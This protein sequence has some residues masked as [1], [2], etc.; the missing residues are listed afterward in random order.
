MNPLLD[1]YPDAIEINGREYAIRTDYRYAVMIETAAMDPSVAECERA[2]LMLDL[3]YPTRPADDQA[4]WD[5]LAAYLR[6]GEEPSKGEPGPRALD[7]QIDWPLIVAAYRQAYGIDLATAQMHWWEFVALLRGL[8]ETCQLAQIMGYRVMEIPHNMS[9]EQKKF[10]RK[11]KSK[12]ALPDGQKKRGLSDVLGA[13]MSRRG[14]NGGREGNHRGDT[15][16]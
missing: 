1:G 14:S 5:G 7:F 4:A 11:M 13:A 2:G 16:R 6:M 8:P 3:L 10:Y 15:R 9:D 12:Y